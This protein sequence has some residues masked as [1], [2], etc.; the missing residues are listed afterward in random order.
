MVGAFCFLT[1]TAKH[2]ALRTTRVINHSRT[3]RNQISSYLWC[4]C[5]D[6]LMESNLRVIVMLK[7]KS[8]GPFVGIAGV[9]SETIVPITGLLLLLVLL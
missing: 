4:S 1:L 2:E 3:N 7:H 8:S 6:L 5:K 9:I